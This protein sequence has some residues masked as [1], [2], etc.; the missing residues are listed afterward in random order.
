MTH[1]P[2]AVKRLEGNKQLLKDLYEHLDTL[3]EKVKAF[4]LDTKQED[5]YKVILE[6]KAKK[7]DLK[8]QIW[9]DFANVT[10]DNLE[11]LHE[12]LHDIKF[13]LSNLY[14]KSRNLSAQVQKINLT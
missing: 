11:F 1:D 13:I 5:L 9:G 6:Y 4:D 10:A 14:N 2:S 8:D 3:F 7:E 12:E